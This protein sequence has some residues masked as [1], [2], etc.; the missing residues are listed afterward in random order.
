MPITDDTLKGIVQKEIKNSQS[1]AD[2]EVA[3]D[4]Q[5]AIEYFNGEMNDLKAE[6][7]R[8][9]VM[10]MDVADTLSWMRPQLIDVFLGSDRMCIAEPVGVDDDDDAEMAT[11]LLNYVFLKDNPGYRIVSD[12][13]IDAALCKYA[14]V[15]LWNDTTPEYSI[16]FHSGLSDE[17][18][19]LLEQDEEV[20]ITNQT[21]T[22]ERIPVLDLETGV[23]EEA[24]VNQHEVKIRRLRRKGVRRI[25]VIPPEDFYIDAEAT[26]LAE[27]RFRAHRKATT[28]S[29]LIKEGFDRKTIDRIG[30]DDEDTPEDYA[31]QKYDDPDDAADRSTELL[32]RWEIMLDVDVDDDGMAETVRIIYAGSS[33]GGELLDWEVWED[34][35]LFYD[36]PWEPVPHK[37]A[38]KSLADDTIQIQ[39]MKTAMLRQ[40]FD[41]TYASNNPRM[42]VQGEIIN[43]DALFSPTFG[44][45]VFGKPGSAVT[46]LPVPFVAN[47][48]YEA[49]AYADD[50]L[51]RRTGQGRQ[52]MALD[53][54]VLQN[55]T[56]TANQ[57]NHDASYSQTE[58]VA[59]DMAELGWM[60][61][62]RALL[63]MEIKHQDRPRNL[64]IGKELVEVDPRHWNADMGITINLGLG[65]GN[66]QRD[67]A[68]LQGVAGMQATLTQSLMAN[69]A[70]DEAIDMLPKVV[71][72][73]KQTVEAAGLRSPDF[74]F[75][76]FDEDRVTKLKAQ[77]QE[78][79]NQPNP[80]VLKEQA[81]AQTQIQLKQLDV[82][83]QGEKERLQAEYNTAEKEMAARYQAQVD[84]LQAQYTDAENQRKWQFEYTKLAQQR[85]LELMKLG[86][87]EKTDGEGNAVT[88]DSNTD[89]IMR[90]M[91][92]FGQTLAQLAASMNAPTEIVRDP[93]TGRAIGSRKVVN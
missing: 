32:D 47:H 70:V 51:Q 88:V 69:G 54:D 23:T 34:E 63:K 89:A 1:S 31:R 80:E 57:N 6:K 53:P 92:A 59:R 81:K 33:S 55:Q 5:K 75:V 77:A 41:N 49:L 30:A 12:T 61:L 83:V 67:M 13:I 21:T 26:S 87:V 7:G 29:E 27:S 36:I 86:M 85:E 14:I 46:P 72:T 9:A 65:T 74:Y 79:A 82:Q 4:R 16:S 91:D 50:M 35:Q 44:E 11:H 73:M 25:E 22:T 38:G 17:Q 43:P 93:A 39:K 8:S 24:D 90:T 19:A 78:A 58:M 64:R 37:F 3:K 18:I 62:F 76:D 68:M 84:A 71:E 28:R 42:F 60:P 15:K 40:V 66:R 45:H 2:A 20:E 48:G 10:S 56:A 52:T